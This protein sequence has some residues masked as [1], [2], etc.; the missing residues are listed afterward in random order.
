MF[1]LSYPQFHFVQT[2]VEGRFNSTK[3][4]PLLLL[5]IVQREQFE[6]EFL[7]IALSLLDISFTSDEISGPGIKEYRVLSQL[8]TFYILRAIY[9]SKSIRSLSP[10]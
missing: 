1:S 5:A 6:V 4:A 9:E 8:P 10:D 2:S 3:S 7:F